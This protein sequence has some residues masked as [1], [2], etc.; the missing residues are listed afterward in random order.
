MVGFTVGGPV[1]AI[2]TGVGSAYATSRND[3]LGDVARAMGDVGMVVANKILEVSEKH[4]ISQKV[5]TAKDENP[6]ISKSM[7]IVVS[8]M[9]SVKEFDRRHKLTERMLNG[10]KKFDKSHKLTESIRARYWEK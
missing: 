5:K 3:A 2:V 8:S 4:Q 9:H 10:I 6:I 7:K 1:F